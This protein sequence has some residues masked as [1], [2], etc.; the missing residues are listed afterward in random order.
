MYRQLLSSAVIAALL[1]LPWAA[2]AYQPTT[3]VPAPQSFPVSSYYGNPQ[4]VTISGYQ[5][6]AMQ[7]PQLTPDG[8]TLLFDSHHD[9]LDSTPIWLYYAF[10]ANPLVFS[11]QGGVAP[12]A[13][14]NPSGSAQLT[15]SVDAHGRIYFFQQRSVSLY[16]DGIVTASYSAGTTSNGTLVQG[17]TPGAPP[18]G[19]VSS[20]F[21]DPFVTPDGSVLFLTNWYTNSANSPVYAQC[22]HATRN[23]DGTFTSHPDSPLLATINALGPKVY[24]CAP[25]PDGLRV[26]F[27][28][29]TTVGPQI[30][31]ATAV[32][33]GQPFV[34]PA[35]LGIGV[36][37]GNL[38]IENGAP[39]A[40][41]A[42][43][44]YHQILS[45][46]AS[47]VLYAPKM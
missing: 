23:P 6:S 13:D 43:L 27:T 14:V 5:G 11:Y 37:S 33:P 42:G 28:A 25:T 29:V 22:V 46:T 38:N 8:S 32:A 40:D 1:S 24:N 12:Q 26:V 3:V 44:Y 21:N 36:F 45:T 17:I 31:I 9:A 47:R 19:T 39:T 2:R 7:D 35:I 10:R 20:F 30:F 41:G 34:N 18:A 15:G 4:P 16:G